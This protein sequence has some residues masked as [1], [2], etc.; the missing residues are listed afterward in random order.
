[1]Q[2]GIIGLNR[3]A[4]F[5]VPQESPD[6]EITTRFLIRA[7]APSFTDRV[8]TDLVGSL[9]WLSTGRCAALCSSC[10]V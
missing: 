2:V 4:L 6:L 9:Q 5:S 3:L 8:G 10:E 1:M 7:R